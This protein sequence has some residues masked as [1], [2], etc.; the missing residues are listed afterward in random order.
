METVRSPFIDWGVASLS[1]AAEK[2]SGDAYVVKAGGKKF[3]AAVIDGLG[4]GDLAADAAAIA[5][6]ILTS[7]SLDDDLV[8]LVRQCHEAL[9]RTRGVVLSLALFDAANHT[10][11]WLG[12]GNVD[13]LL[14]R[15]DPQAN[16]ARESL[17]HRGGVVGYQLPPLR[18]STT[19]VGRGDLLVFY[20][21]G[22]GSGFGKEANPEIAPRQI[23]DMI[24]TDYNRGNDD[25]L[26][27][28]VR[29]T[30]GQA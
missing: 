15:S 4:H 24:M 26:V 25:A 14:F 16:P 28:A 13:G 6:G 20:T 30:G 21:D 17:L 3:L 29:Y 27:L 10:M 19:H 22:I 11:T 8:S 7:R 9:L 23:A 1:L 5:A 18:P 12:V 2:R